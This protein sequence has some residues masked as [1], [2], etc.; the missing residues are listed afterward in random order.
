MLNDQ[1]GLCGTLPFRLGNFRL[2]RL[3]AGIQPP[4]ESAPVS[5]IDIIP[6]IYAALGLKPPYEFIGENLLPVMGTGP[7]ELP[8]DRSRFAHMDR[9]LAIYKF[10][11]Q[12]TLWAEPKSARLMNWRTGQ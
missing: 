8:D 3:G 1:H 9:N 4:T 6:T 12:L 11:W 2:G 7:G 5:G 10:D